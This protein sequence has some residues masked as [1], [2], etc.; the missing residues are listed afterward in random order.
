M[1]EVRLQW[2]RD[3][4]EAALHGELDL[5]GGAGHPIAM[6]LGAAIKH[7][8]L[9]GPL[10]H[11][12]TEARAFDLYNDPMPD[13]AAFHGY[14]DKTAS[15]PFALS[16]TIMGAAVPAS[17]IDNAG[18]ALGRARLLTRL[19][20]WLSR[21]RNPLPST[22][23]VEVGCDPGDLLAGQWT[24]GTRRLIT[25]VAADATADLVQ[26]RRGIANLS[27]GQRV[28]FLPLATI[29]PYLAS[30]TR[31]DHN[32]LTTTSDI[33]ALKRVTRIAQAHWFGL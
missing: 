33:T 23:L 24:A 13:S 21:G 22:L 29:R 19:P 11:A 8:R 15:V 7:H 4:I 28:I 27:R 25:R 10:L 18:R 9:A 30:L 26:A 3:V 12:M 1:G 20:A 31:T 17:I 6:S 2:W 16:A 5:G 14:L 32:P